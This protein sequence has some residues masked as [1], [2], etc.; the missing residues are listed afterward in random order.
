MRVS[1]CGRV[2]LGCAISIV[3]LVAGT[4]AAYAISAQNF[5]LPMRFVYTH[6]AKSTKA[7]KKKKNTSSNRGPRGPQGPIGKTGPAGPTGLTG[8]AGSTGPTGP[9]GP[10]ATKI[11]FFEAPSPTDGVHQLLTTGP[12]QLGLSCQ[13]EPTGKGEIKL[14][15]FLTL[16][17][18]LTTLSAVPF[19]GEPTYETATGSASNVAVERKV[20][21]GSGS[22]GGIFVVVGSDGVPYWVSIDYGANTEETTKS[23]IGV[24]EKEPRGCWFMAEEI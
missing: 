22:S 13:G 17:G 12:L 19:T 24:I 16:P 2:M 11:N 5:R 21:T 20:P 14:I 6:H 1:Q 15:T 4:G 23:S 3:L 7:K 10:G 18:P 9:Q 8:S